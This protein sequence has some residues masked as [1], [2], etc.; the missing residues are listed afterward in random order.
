VLRKTAL[1]PHLSQCLPEVPWHC[2]DGILS[3]GGGGE[4]ASQAAWIFKMS[5]LHFE[6]LDE[7]GFFS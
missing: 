5:P 6:N 3:L 7:T 2:V 4:S 1:L